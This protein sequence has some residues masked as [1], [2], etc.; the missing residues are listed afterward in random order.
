[1]GIS[2]P[3]KK[4][5]SSL[6]SPPPPKWLHLSYKIRVTLNEKFIVFV[7]NHD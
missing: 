2:E 7:S 6:Y 4:R 1:M 5:F 3:K